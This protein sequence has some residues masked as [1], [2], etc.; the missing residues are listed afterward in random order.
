MA[1]KN[2]KLAW[3]MAIGGVVLIGAGAWVFWIGP[4][5]KK[6][7]LEKQAKDAA[8]KASRDGVGG[9]PSLPSIPAS[10]IPPSGAPPVVTSPGTTLPNAVT[11]GGYPLQYGAKGTRV[12]IIQTVLKDFSGVDIGRAGVDGDWGNGTD[13]GLKDAYGKS[14]LN[15]SDFIFF[16]WLYELKQGLGASPADNKEKAKVVL[17]NTSNPSVNNIAK[18]WWEKT[19]GANANKKREDFAKNFGLGFTMPTYQGF[20]N[21]GGGEEFSTT[22]I[23]STFKPITQRNRKPKLQK[24][25]KFNNC[26]GGSGVNWPWVTAPGTLY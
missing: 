2:K 11:S 26:G 7:R 6:K 10:A 17:G 8:D 21:A 19:F 25:Q 18:A 13:R 9:S 15:E 1:I 24:I 16:N 3:G 20:S 14:V 5:I 12:E 4:A 23:V 22:L